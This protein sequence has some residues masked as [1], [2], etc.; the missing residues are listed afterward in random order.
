MQ[1]DSGIVRGRYQVKPVKDRSFPRHDTPMYV[2]LDIICSISLA[3]IRS[4]GL[5]QCTTMSLFSLSSFPPS[6]FLISLCLRGFQYGHDGYGDCYHYNHR[7][8]FGYDQR[9]EH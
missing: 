6:P 7:D 9:L 1:S 3:L 5:V 4:F 8:R 2:F